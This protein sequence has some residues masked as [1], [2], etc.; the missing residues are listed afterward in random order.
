MPEVPAQYLPAGAV[1]VPVDAEDAG[2]SQRYRPAASAGP[3]PTV[4]P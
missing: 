2:G 1:Y 4:L 3:Q